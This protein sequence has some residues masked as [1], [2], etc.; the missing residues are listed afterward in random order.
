MPSTEFQAH[1]GIAPNRAESCWIQGI[2]ID[3]EQ[4]WLLALQASTGLASR[5]LAGHRIDTAQRPSC[6]PLCPTVSSAAQRDTA[7]CGSTAHRRAPP[8]PSSTAAPSGTVAPMDTGRLVGYSV[9]C[10]LQVY[11]CHSIETKHLKSQR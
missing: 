2:G 1:R 7:H 5:R 10:Q 3:T 8:A 11:Y 9:S 4:S 6:H